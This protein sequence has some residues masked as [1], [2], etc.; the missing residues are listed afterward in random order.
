MKYISSSAAD[1]KQH[2]DVV[3]I[4]SGY[5]GS[6]AAS[7]MSRA[8]KKV[9]LLEKGKEFQP[10]DYPKSN[11]EAAKEVQLDLCGNHIGPSTGLYDFRVNDDISVAMGCGLGGTSLVNASVSVLP[12]PRVFEDKCWPEE[13]RNDMQSFND[14]VKHAR[15]MLGPVEYPEEE[16]GYPKLPK[17]EAMRKAADKI[18]AKCYKL[19]I[20][21]TFEDWVNRSGVKQAKCV[22]CGDCVTGC[23]YASKNTAL[24]NYLPDAVNH[25]AEIYT[26]IL[27]RYIR[28]TGDLWS[29]HFQMYDTDRENFD[30]AEMVVKADIVILAAGSL[31]S[32]EILLRSN[33]MGLSLS[34]KLGDRFSGNGDTT[35]IGYNNDQKIN[36][37]GLGYHKP[38]DG[39]E[40]PGPTITAVID[41]RNQDK[42]DEGIVIEEGVIPG[43]MAKLLPHAFVPMSRLFGKDTDSGMVDFVKEKWRELVSLTRGAYHG[44]IKNTIT[45]LVNTHDGAGGKMK[46]ENDRLRVDWPGVGKQPIFDKIDEKLKDVTSALGGTK[47]KNP[48]W[49]KILDYDLI[50]VHPLGGCVMADSAENGVVNHKGELFTSDNGTD[51]HKGLYVCDGAV[52]PRSLG[53][54]PL[55]TISALAERCCKLIAKDNGWVIDYNFF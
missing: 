46:L 30:T 50:T 55:L 9:C 29:V 1:I 14:G 13:L 16:K 19:N 39:V 33:K 26:K 8:G 48:V 27:V 43:A 6:I 3:V 32:T 51:V 5:G 47:I 36:G 4:G 49:N 22:L 23:N 24:M 35:G 10:G 52:V 2:Y 28:K 17:L 53:A 25:G 21:V 41:L 45:Y 44:A 40:L 31:G 12:E 11:L 7:R 37:V 42:L 38:G 20:N 54:N 18:N 15:E 34:G